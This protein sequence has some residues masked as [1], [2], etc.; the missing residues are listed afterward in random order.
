MGEYWN[1]S[2]VVDFT[3]WYLRLIGVQQSKEIKDTDIVLSYQMGVNPSLKREEP[4]IGSILNYI[5]YYF[6]VTPE[7]LRGKSRKRDH[8]YPRQ[9]VVYLL[10]KY[11]NLSLEKAGSVVLKGHATAYYSVKQIQSLIKTDKSVKKEI[12]DIRIRL[13]L[14]Y[15]Y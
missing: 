14:F 11:K 5:C 13:N 4:K 15:K 6:G 3:N 8:V 2:R 7:I 1:N 12:E 10:R 9:I